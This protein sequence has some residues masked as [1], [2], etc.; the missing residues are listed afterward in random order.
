MLWHDQCYLYLSWLM[1]F[2]TLAPNLEFGTHL[3]AVKWTLRISFCFGTMFVVCSLTCLAKVRRKKVYLPYIL[4]R[5]L[6][7]ASNNSY[8]MFHRLIP[9]CLWRTMANNDNFI[10]IAHD[11]NVL[12]CYL[13]IPCSLH[14]LCPIDFTC[15]SYHF[16]RTFCWQLNQIR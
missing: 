16:Q 8:D 13:S 4:Y 11:I 7:G 5:F 6:H 14:L 1:L 3:V 10:Y 9:V 2:F 15:S 12:F